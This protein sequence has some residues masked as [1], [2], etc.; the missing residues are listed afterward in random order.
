VIHQYD[1]E[2]LTWSCTSPPKPPGPE[3]KPTLAAGYIVL[4]V[5]SCILC[6]VILVLVSIYYKKRYNMRRQ[7]EEMREER[8]DRNSLRMQEEFELYSLL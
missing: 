7:Y 2:C 6:I 3:P 5:I 8:Y 4:L 1:V